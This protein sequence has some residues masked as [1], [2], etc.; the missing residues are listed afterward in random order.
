MREV[1]GI[2]ATPLASDSIAM[3]WAGYAS[4]KEEPAAGA[5]VE[6]PFAS[7]LPLRSVFTTW[8]SMGVSATVMVATLSITSTR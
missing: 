6:V 1:E 5:S 2:G 4:V 7:G 8:A 3:A